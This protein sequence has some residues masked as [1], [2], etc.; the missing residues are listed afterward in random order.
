[1]PFDQGML[2]SVAQVDL[3]DATTEIINH[4]V[5]R[6]PLQQEEA[7]P[8]AQVAGR[9]AGSRWALFVLWACRMPAAWAG[10]ALW[11]AAAR[12]CQAGVFERTW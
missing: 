3:P 2:L 11:Q 7:R 12:G 4:F 5:G 10:D 6:S 9:A 1:M 8:R